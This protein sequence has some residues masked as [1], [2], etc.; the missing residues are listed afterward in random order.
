MKIIDK[1]NSDYFFEKIIYIENK[2]KITP[3]Q[4]VKKSS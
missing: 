3:K 2:V 1:N 4:V